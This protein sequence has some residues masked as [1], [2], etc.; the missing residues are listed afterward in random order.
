MTE[1]NNS[2]RIAYQLIA[3]L[4]SS[5][6]EFT[7]NKIRH[8]IESNDY[9]ALRAWYDIEEALS[10]IQNLRTT[11]AVPEPISIHANT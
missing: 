2:Y 4:G 9:N 10:E 11:E 1:I 6:N 3:E 8:Y 5:A 7:Q